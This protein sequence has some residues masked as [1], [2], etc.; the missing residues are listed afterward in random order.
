MN[1]PNQL[2]A[3]LLTPSRYRDL[4]GP[5]EKFF[6]HPEYEPRL[7]NWAYDDTILTDEFQWETYDYARHIAQRDGFD[8]IL[9]VGCGS[10]YKLVHWFANYRTLGLDLP[11]LVRF[12]RRTYP[13][14]NWQTADLDLETFEGYGVA[15]VADVIEHLVDPDI[16]IRFLLRSRPKRIVISTPERDLLHHGTWN[17]PPK[18][19]HHVREWNYAQFHSYLSSAFHVR[20][21]FVWDRAQVA[22]LE[23]REP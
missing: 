4:I 11:D 14:Q 12:L 5:A 19:I 7:D 20:E 3:T 22:E 10:G 6:I 13:A 8:S 2:P 23:L 21:H 16:L 17:G 15:I 1:H 9:D 18:N